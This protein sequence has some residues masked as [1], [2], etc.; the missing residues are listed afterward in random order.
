MKSPAA[1]LSSSR[2]SSLFHSGKNFHPTRKLLACLMLASVTLST[3]P[4]NVQASENGNLPGLI[5]ERLSY[6]KDVASSKAENHQP[7]EVVAQ[8]DRVLQ[9]TQKVAEGLGLDPNSVKPFIVA[10]MSAAK[11]IQYRYRADWLSTPETDWKPRPLESI[12][13]DIAGLSTRILQRLAVELKANGRISPDNQAEFIAQLQQKNLNEAD[14]I[15]LFKT[16]EQVRLK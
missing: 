16:L 3:L 12:R 4:L 6:M 5:N 13:Q 9:D 1:Y 10:Q 8:E 2:L 7:V 15:L 14:K 11:A